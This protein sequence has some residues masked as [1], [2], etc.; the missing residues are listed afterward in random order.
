[1]CSQLSCI[2]GLILKNCKEAEGKEIKQMTELFCMEEL[3]FLIWRKT[4]G[5]YLRNFL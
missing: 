4:H 2:R 3:I 5:W 1:M